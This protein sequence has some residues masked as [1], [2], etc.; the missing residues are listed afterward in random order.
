M[1]GAIDVAGVQKLGCLAHTLNLASKKVLSLPLLQKVLAKV[2]S[3][4]TFFHKSN[5]ATEALQEKQLALQLPKHKFINDCK[6]SLNS[7]YQML[8]R[9]L[10]QKPAVL[11]ALLDA[12]IKKNDKAGTVR[13]LTDQEIQCCEEFV[14]IIGVMLTA[15]L[16]LCEEKTP[17]SG[18]ILPLLDKLLKHFERK[19]GDSVFV[20]S[21]KKCS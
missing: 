1:T 14:S 10:K 4:V 19:E 17:T 6:T 3:V 7:T 5:I 12:R 15:T 21:L 8:E 16:I 18:L 11:A 2:R 13:G 20:I 9:F